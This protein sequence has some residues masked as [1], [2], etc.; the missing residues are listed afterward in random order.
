[1]TKNP[2]MV[3]LE[4]R[5]LHGGSFTQLSLSGPL[6]SAPQKAVLRRMLA[7]FAHW[8][9]APIRVVLHVDAQT[10]GWCELWAD[11]LAAVP[12]CHLEVEFVPPPTPVPEDRR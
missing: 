3:T 12:S 5:P 7:A 10:A 1:M 2:D 6:C 11:A 4:L 8:S 9:G